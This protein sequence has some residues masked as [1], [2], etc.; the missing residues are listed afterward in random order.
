MSARATRALLLAGLLVFLAGTARDL[1]WHATH[2]TQSEF[3][4][5]SKQIEVHWLLW[6]GALIV[7]AA[8]GMA[9]RRLE[10]TQKTRGYLVAFAAGIA[11]ALI[12]VWHFIEHANGADPEVAHIFLYVSA[13]LMLAGVVRALAVTALSRQRPVASGEG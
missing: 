11:Y 9:M 2:D 4:T 10:L 5:A 8:A 6:L 12:S 1:Q 13:G 3:E 7:I